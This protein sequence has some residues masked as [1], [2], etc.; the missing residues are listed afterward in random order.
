MIA[1]LEGV[2]VARDPEASVVDV[3]GVGYAV[4]HSLHTYSDLPAVGTRLALFTHLHV[5]EDALQL[6]GFSTAEERRL[7]ELLIGVSGVGPKVALAVLS[8][9]AP[10]S[11]ARAVKDENL[12]ALTRIAGVGKKTAERIVIDL[13]DKMPPALVAAAGAGVSGPGPAT[14]AD[15]GGARG[16][17]KPAGADGPAEGPL[18]GRLFEDACAALV[19][20]GVSRAGAIEDVRRAMEQGPAGDFETLVRRALALSVPRAQGPGVPGVR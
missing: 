19:A 20:L 10:A 2:L 17:R 15:E 13:R 11:F 5:R 16:R 18:P 6:Y 4:A 9:L 14:A 1:R 7:F 8:G 3:A 12:G